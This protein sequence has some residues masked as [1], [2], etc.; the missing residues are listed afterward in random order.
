MNKPFDS[1]VSIDDEWTPPD[2]KIVKDDEIVKSS[3]LIDKAGH[4]GVTGWVCPVCGRGN[5]P[6]NS[7]CSCKGYVP[8][9]VTC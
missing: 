5:A 2:L 8:F 9:Q 7:T 6:W 3:Q 4:L 1:N